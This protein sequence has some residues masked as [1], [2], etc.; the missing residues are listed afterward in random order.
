MIESTFTK[1]IPP[2]RRRSR[3]RLSPP[4]CLRRASSHIC[5]CERRIPPAVSSP[6]PGLFLLSP[7]LRTDMEGNRRIAVLRQA[8]SWGAKLPSGRF[9]AVE[10]VDPAQSPQPPRRQTGS[11]HR[12]E[13]A[14]SKW[15]STYSAPRPDTEGNK[16]NDEAIPVS[17]S[18]GSGPTWDEDRS[19]PAEAMAV[20]MEGE[21]MDEGGSGYLS[22]RGG[23]GPMVV[24]EG[25]NSGA[26]K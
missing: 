12:V 6:F 11:T 2:Q 1:V 18:P 21:E 8:S 5:E 13:C 22:T 7:P 16:P 4:R 25:G 20:E 26:N 24:G 15:W 19:S 10:V 3:P 23:W 14:R 9:L 17:S